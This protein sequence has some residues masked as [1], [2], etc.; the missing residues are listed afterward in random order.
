MYNTPPVFPIYDTLLTL[1]WLK[2]MGGIKWIT[3]LNTKKANA[4]YSE[5]DRNSMFYGTTAVEDRSQ[6]NAC[7]LMNKPELEAE[8]DKFWK[9]AGISGIRGHRDVGG[10]RAS[11]Y[12]ALPIESVQVLVEVMKEFEK[13]FA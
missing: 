2:K 8:F 11:M 10:Y 7:F 4:L 1:Q 5:I 13:K 6:M 12:N 9:D 3:D